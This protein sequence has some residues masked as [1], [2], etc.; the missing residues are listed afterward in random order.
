MFIYNV[1]AEVLDF[2]HEAVA[3]AVFGGE[4]VLRADAD[5]GEVAAFV[6][7]VGCVGGSRQF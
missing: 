6:T 5:V 2:L 3:A 1:A 7:V 4:E